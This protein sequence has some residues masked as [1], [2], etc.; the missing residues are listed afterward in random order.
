MREIELGWVGA[1]GKPRSPPTNALRSLSFYNRKAHISQARAYLGSRL[2]S[3]GLLSPPAANLQLLSP[4][5]AEKIA[6][7]SQV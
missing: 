2:I 3:R 7:A 5:A 4:P 1:I 6:A